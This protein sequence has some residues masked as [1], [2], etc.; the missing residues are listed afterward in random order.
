MKLSTLTKHFPVNIMWDWTQIRLI[1]STR[2]KAIE[3]SKY[4]CSEMTTFHTDFNSHLISQSL[5]NFGHLTN[6]FSLI[7]IVYMDFP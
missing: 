7:Y 6:A 2:H 3:Q 1:T 4:T 5:T